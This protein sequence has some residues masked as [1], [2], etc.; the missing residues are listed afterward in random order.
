MRAVDAHQRFA[1]RIKVLGGKPE[2]L[3]LLAL[4][5][6]N[7]QQSGLKRNR[8]FGEIKC[9]MLQDGNNIQSTLVQQAWKRANMI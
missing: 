8:G 4:A 7:L 1:G 9:T 6:Q 3:E 5:F 2:H